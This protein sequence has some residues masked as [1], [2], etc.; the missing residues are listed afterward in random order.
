MYINTPN[1]Q[2]DDWVEFLDSNTHQDCYTP[3]RRIQG[4]YKSDSPIKYVNFSQRIYIVRSDHIRD[5][6]H[7]S[8]TTSY[9]LMV[10]NTSDTNR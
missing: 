2:L 7:S 5:W 8:I 9:G 3:V 1:S 10:A 6:F 4:I